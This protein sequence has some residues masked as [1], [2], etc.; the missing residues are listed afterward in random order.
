VLIHFHDIFFPFEYPRIWVYQG[1]NWNE[2]YLLRAFLMNNAAYQ[3]EFFTSFMQ[4]F[5]SEKFATMPLFGKNSGA[6]IWLRKTN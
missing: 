6:S 2:A 3:I 1:R 5:H 4:T